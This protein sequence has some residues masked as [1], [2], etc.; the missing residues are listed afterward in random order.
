[1][2]NGWLFDTLRYHGMHKEKAERLHVEFVIKG[3]SLDER[4]FSCYKSLCF[5]SDLVSLYDRQPFNLLC[6]LSMYHI[7]IMAR[8]QKT[9]NRAAKINKN[10]ITLPGEA[11][12]QDRFL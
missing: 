9:T 1:M 3:D 7:P 11:K 6:S 10:Q 4:A 12:E 2:L 5:D 8:Q